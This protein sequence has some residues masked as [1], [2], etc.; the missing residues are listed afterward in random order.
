LISARHS[1]AH[2]QVLADNPARH[3]RTSGWRKSPWLCAQLACL[4]LAAPLKADE[5]AF[6]TDSPLASETGYVLVEWQ[7]GEAVSLEMAET[8]DFADATELYNGTNSSFFVSG[9]QD[10]DYFLRLRT[11]D[12][13]QADP[14]VLEVRHQSLTQA[15]W[16][17]LLGAI[18]T[19]AVV[20]AILRGARDE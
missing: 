1:S 15:L 6:T 16:L 20:A 8:A 17:A 2:R 3:R 14:L 13:A 12:G 10:G 19:I 11:A 18:V 9:L 7:A 5:P 4:A